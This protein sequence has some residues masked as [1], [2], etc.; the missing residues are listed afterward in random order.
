MRKETRDRYLAKLA[1]SNQGKALFD[2]I[3]ERATELGRINVDP[4][5]KNLTDIA[6]DNIASDRAVKILYNIKQQIISLE[7]QGNS[8]EFDDYI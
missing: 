8:H 7:K 2:L 6:I 1:K 3:D 4:N 5:I